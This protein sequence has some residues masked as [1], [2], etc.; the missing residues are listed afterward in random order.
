MAHSIRSHNAAPARGPTQQALRSEPANDAARVPAKGNVALVASILRALQASV[1]GHPVPEAM[2]PFFVAQITVEAAARE[3]RT[4]STG[5]VLDDA[6][7]ALP[8]VIGAVMAGQVRGFGPVEMRYTIDLAADL[9]QRWQLRRAY[10]GVRGSASAAKSV[11]M[12]TL[13]SARSAVFNMIAS[14]APAGTPE[15]DALD[16]NASMKRRTLAFG[17]ASIDSMAAQANDLLARGHHDAAFGAYLVDKG[18]TAEALRATITPAEPALRARE[19]HRVA[20]GASATEQQAVDVI[21]GR[22]RHQLMQLRQR[23]EAERARGASLPEVRLTRVRARSAS[24]TVGET[25]TPP[26]APTPA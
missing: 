23:V 4:L 12:D 10:E 7:E 8:P 3:G 18:F 13:W 17:L 25:V 9:A 22:L 5:D 2:R 1:A 26:P 15:R 6:A 11:S 14:V 24:T 21:E 20:K 16:K 19:A